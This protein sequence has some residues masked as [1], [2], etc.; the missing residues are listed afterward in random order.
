MSISRSDSLIFAMHIF[1]TGSTGFI[2]R[3]TTSYL[4]GRGH[5]ITV[6]VRNPHRAN[7]LLGQGI[8]I[9]PSSVSLTELTRRF[10]TTDVVVNLA[11]SPIATRWNRKRK[12]EI[13]DSRI[14][15]TKFLVDAINN[16]QNP[17]QLLISASAVGYYGNPGKPG[18]DESSEK[19]DGFLSDLSAQWEST[20]MNVQNNRTR[21]CLLRIGIV[22]GREGGILKTLTPLFE[23]HLGHYIAS[24][25]IMPWIH[26]SDLVKIIGFCITNTSLSGPVNCTAPTPVT[27]KE[28]A[29]ALKGFVRSKFLLRIPNLLLKPVLG[30][31][32]TVL[33]NS[34][35]VLPMVLNKNSFD[36]DFPTIRQAL[37][38]EFNQ[39]AIIIENNSSATDV[40]T[41]SLRDKY[42]VNRNGQYKLTS[43]MTLTGTPK[44]LFNF[45]SSPLNLGGL[46]PQWMNFQILDIPKQIS[47]GSIIK[48]RIGLGPFKLSWTTIIVS[49]NPNKSFIDLQ[50]RGPYSF[51]WHEHILNQKTTNSLVMIDRVIYRIPGGIFGRLIHRLFI[52]KTLLRIFRFR[53]QSIK[54]RF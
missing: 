9:I 17:P 35:N 19:G 13:R 41:D 30:E 26:I 31:A 32:S 20:A 48:Y 39:K 36:F 2:G 1:I 49:W 53:A 25:P 14:G 7:D 29:T 52:K 44:S 15:I 33:T 34:Q 54:L 16:C 11:G 10:E 22:I 42:S 12:Q 28:F 43:T 51:W 46:T 5:T 3:F 8:E 45:F 50:E 18:V 23:T 38:A 40:E 6:L 27:N 4:Q 24:D 21:I 47:E 37:D